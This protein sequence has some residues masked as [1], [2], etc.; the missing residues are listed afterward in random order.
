[1]F[2]I[3]HDRL[4]EELIDRRGPWDELEPEDYPA[5][6]VRA[7]QIRA[8]ALL[9]AFG[10][11]L[12]S[13]LTDRNATMC[14]IKIRF[15]ALCFGLGLNLIEGRTMSEVAQ[16]L[17]VERATLSKIAVQFCQANGLDPSWH[18][19]KSGTGRTYTMG[20]LESIARRNAKMNGNGKLPAIPKRGRS[21]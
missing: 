14:D 18:M 17:G 5:N 12:E 15:Y 8:V 4:P 16:N 1:M 3:D 20:R 13:V 9:N 7:A 21:V 19:K 2:D 6:S 11:S 10:A